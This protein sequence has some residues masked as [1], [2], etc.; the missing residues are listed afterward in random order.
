ML[1]FVSVYLAISAWGFRHNTVYLFDNA[2]NR[3]IAVD[4]TV[5]RDS[6]LKA[7]SGLGILPVAIFSHGNAVKRCE[8]TFLANVFA[9]H[10][11]FVACIQH[12]QP[13]DPP[14]AMMFGV[15]F[16]GRLS[17]YKRGAAN[18]L[19]VLQELKRIEPAADLA[20]LTLVGHSN[21][22]DISMF[23]ARQNPNLVKT[24]VTLDNLRVPLLTS[25]NFHIL[26]I[27]SADMKP[28][29]GVVPDD[30]QA[31]AA[32][33]DIVRIDAR[34]VEMSDRGPYL[35]KRGIK[36]SLQRFLNDE[37]S[38]LPNNRPYDRD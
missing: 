22:G 9:L 3:P 23:F 25:N 4:I 30:T 1:T 7:E 5:R 14:L 29:P 12:D 24:V 27:R 37:S 13:T 31:K 16:K 17:L 15:P 18:I 32:R 26:S 10:G 8:Y 20:H 33:I 19:F 2:R 35:V 38:G 28:D 34:H 36:E 21:G 6:E 11:Y